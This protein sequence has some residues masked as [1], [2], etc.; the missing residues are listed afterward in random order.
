[1]PP[2]VPVQTLEPAIFN[3]NWLSATGAGILIAALI[4]AVVMRLKGK[5]IVQVFGLSAFSTRFTMITIASL[6]GLGFLTRFCGLDAT[7][8]LAFART[9]VLCPFFGTFIGWLGTSST[10]YDT[11]SNVLFGS[12]QKLTAQ[13]L[14]TS[15]YLMTEPT[16]AAL[17]ARWSLRRASSWPAPRPA[18]TARRAPS[19][20]LSSSTASRSPA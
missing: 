4:A 8:V 11:S 2:A 9:G 13:Q 1:M 6:M 5:D 17:W 3:F 14:H 18:A 7:L 10:G 19:S 16:P 12:L 15:P 20:V